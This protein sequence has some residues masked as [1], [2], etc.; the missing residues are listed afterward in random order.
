MTLFNGLSK[1][2]Y[3]DL[4]KY[5]FN[6]YEVMELVDN[7]NKKA[8]AE[9]KTANGLKMFSKKRI[10]LDQNVDKIKELTKTHTYSEIAAMYGLTKAA[11]YAW[12][13]KQRRNGVFI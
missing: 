1:E 2:Q 9:W 6:D 10:H 11:F 4:K 7:R 12:I 13:L 5:G 3:I 8:L